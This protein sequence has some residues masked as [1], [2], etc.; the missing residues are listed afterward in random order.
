M[1][2]LIEAKNIKVVRDKNIILNDISL[3][4]KNDDFITIIGPNGAGKSMLLKCLMNF[5]KPN[6]GKI[7][8]KKNL[9]IGYVPQ[10]L[11]NNRQFPISV[12][13][14]LQLN[15]KID[16]N[17][18]LQI[19]DEV[20]IANILQKQLFVLSGGEMQRVLLAFALLKNPEILILDE[21]AQ[22]LDISGQ[23]AFYEIIENIY[24]NSKIAIIMVSHDLHL[25]MAS[26]KKVICLFHHICCEGTP[27][28]ITKDPEFTKIF[29]DKMNNM[30]AIYNHSHNHIHDFCKGENA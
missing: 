20:K 19:I 10:R 29:G 6:S 13:K 12:E 8:H 14:F 21:P 16:Q 3:T 25:V 26:S 2:F 4:I 15:Q 5:Y 18:F 9:S 30:M 7:S 1:S 27:Q 11:E 23:L 28:E 24:K 22:N 17:K